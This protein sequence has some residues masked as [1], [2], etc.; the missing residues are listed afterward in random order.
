MLST[1]GYTSQ[2]AKHLFNKP[3]PHGAIVRIGIEVTYRF[4][5]ITRS[6]EAIGLRQS[7]RASR[8]GHILMPMQ[9]DASYRGTCGKPTAWTAANCK[10]N[11]RRL[12]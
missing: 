9:D 8:T 6:P 10:D 12:N 11:M 7:V 4:V 3:S 1:F 2:Q 5:V